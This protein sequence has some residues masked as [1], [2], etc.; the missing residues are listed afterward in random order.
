MGNA[1]KAKNPNNT[2]SN[3]VTK[4]AVGLPSASLVGLIGYFDSLTRA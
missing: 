2:M 4:P 1:R 3:A